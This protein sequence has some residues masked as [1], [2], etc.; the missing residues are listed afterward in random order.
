MSFPWATR[1]RHASCTITSGSVAGTSSSSGRWTRTVHDASSL[2]DVGCGTGFV[3]QAIRDWSS[4]I[5]LVGSD[6]SAEALEIARELVPTATFTQRDAQHLE[7]DEE[8]DVVCA[9]DVLEH[10][11]DD[12]GALVRNRR[13]VE[14]RRE[15]SRQRPS[16][17]VAMERGRRLPRAPPPVHERRDRDE[18][19]ES[20]AH[21]RALVR[22]DGPTP[23]GDCCLAG[24]RATFQGLRPD[25]RVPAAGRGESH[26]RDDSRTRAADD[27]AGTL[28]ALG[29]FAIRRRREGLTS[30]HESYLLEL[31]RF[32]RP[33]RTHSPASTASS[34][35]ALQSATRASCVVRKR[36]STVPTP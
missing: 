30:A 2:L 4:E 12:E 13:S 7:A 23:P 15:G 25:A 21:R 16:V 19:S 27:S 5:E 20:R 31:G 10:L 36:P 29:Q 22:L 33:P 1:H 26:V 18:D 9:F 24:V 8:F 14:A 32:S 11:D 35:S 6:L 17:P 3:L 34:T 28:V